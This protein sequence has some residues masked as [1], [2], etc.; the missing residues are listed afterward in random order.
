[1]NLDKNGTGWNHLEEISGRR[2]FSLEKSF[3]DKASV[4]NENGRG[5]ET[6][7]KIEAVFYV[8]HFLMSL[9]PPCDSIAALHAMNINASFYSHRR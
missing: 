7:V 2:N 9:S 8:D 3:C 5:H 4:E 6:D 1:M